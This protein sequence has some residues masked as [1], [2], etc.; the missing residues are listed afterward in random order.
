M[1][2]LP[3]ILSAALTTLVSP[4]YAL[5]ITNPGLVTSAGSCYFGCTNNPANAHDHSNILDGDWGQTGN[6]GYNSW[7]SG[8]WGG[9]VQVNFGASYIL[10]RIELYGWFSTYDPFTLSVSNNGTSWSSI[11]VGGYHHE[12]GLTQAGASGT[13]SRADDWGAIYDVVT[14]G[15]LAAGVQGQYLRYSV[16]AGSPHWGY[17]FELVVDGHSPVVSTPTPL[18]GGTG[19]GA[20]T[21]PEP[22]SLALFGL[23]LGLLGANTRRKR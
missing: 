9:W 22:T 4:A 13:A 11:A 16:N 20:N 2:T 7:N 5:T 17:L 1:K 19:G 18:G 21:V 10:D 6:T 14:Q 12:P 8:Y 15:N 23:G 3:L